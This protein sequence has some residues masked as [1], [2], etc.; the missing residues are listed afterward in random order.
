MEGNGFTPDS[1]RVTASSENQN[2][3]GISIMSESAPAPVCEPS[4]LEALW[5]ADVKK[6]KKR[7]R[8]R[9][10][11]QDGNSMTLS[12]MPIS[13][14]VP[15][16]GDYSSVA[17][18]TQKDWPIMDSVK[19][20]KK[21][22]E[23]GNGGLGTNFTPHILTV[24]AGEDVSKTIISFSQ[25]GGGSRAICI[26]AANGLISNVTLQQS[27]SSGGTLTHEGQFEILSLTGSFMPMDDGVT[28][29]RSGGMSISL[30]ASD[31]RILGGGLSGC[32]VAAGPVQ[33]V[34]GSFSTDHQLDQQPKQNNHSTQNGT[35][36]SYYY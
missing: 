21:K 15:L 4:T 6:T 20:K 29:S 28:K 19:K 14:S 31:G 35:D 18:W 7:G 9:L 3:P 25:Q 8:P 27:N 24:N 22:H 26:L 33:V 30:S 34:I 11:G 12:P 2:H 23:F 36:E 17:A 32:L 10:N 13:S 5:G 16:A 1:Y